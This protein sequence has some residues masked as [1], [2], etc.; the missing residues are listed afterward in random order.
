[1]LT[2]RA[3]RRCCKQSS[4]TELVYIQVIVTREIPVKSGRHW[5]VKPVTLQ[6]APDPQLM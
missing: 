3:S 2:P 5:I 1:M 6:T 4:S